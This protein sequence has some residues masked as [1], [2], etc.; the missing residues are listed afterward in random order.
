MSV[1]HWGCVCET[2]RTARRASA[3]AAQVP[4]GNPYPW[5]RRG[6][7]AAASGDVSMSAFEARNKGWLSAADTITFHKSRVIADAKAKAIA[8]AEGGYT[9]PD[10]DEPIQVIGA[11]RGASFQLGAQLFAWGGYAS[12]HDQLI[13][14]KIAHVLSGG[15]PA[16]AK[17]VTAQHLLDLEREAFVSLCGEEKT[18]ARIQTMLTTGKPLRN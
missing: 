2:G 11:N 6:F 1:R 16:I 10:P 14:G 3:W 5:V 4:D 15:M 7:E 18:L 17:T 12:E 13:A 8:L 9:P